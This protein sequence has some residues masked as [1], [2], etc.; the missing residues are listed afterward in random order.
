MTKPHLPFIFPQKFLHLYPEDSIFLPDNEYAPRDLPSVA[1]NKWEE[2]RLFKDIRAL[3]VEAEMND[4]LPDNVTL[5]L[6]R[7]YYASV[8]FA[9]EQIGRVLEALSMNDLENDTIV[10]LISDHGFTLGEHSLWG[11]HTNFELTL[12]APFMISIPGLTDDGLETDELVEFVDLFLTL[13]EAAGVPDL[14][15]CPSN[16]AS[17]ALCREGISLMPLIKL[18]EKAV[19]KDAAFSQHARNREGDPLSVMGYSMRTRRYRYTEWVK[20]DRSTYTPQWDEETGWYELYDH[21]VDPE[22]NV[23][24]Y[25][26]EDY[27]EVRQK[28]QRKL[29]A[30]WRSTLHRLSEAELENAMNI[31]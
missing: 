25:N 22:E 24:L 11:K 17:V 26:H 30:G 20:F 21:E 4:T 12:R 19:W 16:S 27:A 5:D 28:L 9:D 15:L 13:V 1:W 3:K 6:R 23:N 2:I 8:S 29:R 14:D 18:R 10:A 7:A 31:Q